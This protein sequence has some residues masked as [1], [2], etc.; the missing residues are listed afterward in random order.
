MN[1]DMLTLQSFIFIAETKSFTKA[2]N[3]IGRTQSAISQQ[4]TKLEQGLNTSLFNRDNTI[5]LTA[6][7]ELFLAYAK[8]IYA[9]YREA[10][11]K[12]K[13]PELTGRIRL[14]LPENFASLYLTEILANFSRIHP[15]ILLEI[16][17]DLTVTLFQRFKDK[18]YDLVLLKMNLPED[19]PYG[20]DM[21]SEPLKWVGHKENATLGDPIS[22][23][24]SP[25]PC[26]YRQAALS[27]L[28]QINLDWRLVFSSPSFASTV[29]AVKAGMGITVMPFTLIPPDL[30]PI[31][32]SLLPK[33]G[34]THL[35][36]VKQV[37]DNP[38][39]NTLEQ[40][41]LKKLRP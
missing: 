11:D 24:L 13:E 17:C 20:V 1:I 23:V 25:E 29:A 2:A 19:I 31:E 30:E 9:L 26:V 22:L 36:L 18:I 16:E 32:S 4:I 6:D 5:C 34:D 14:G 40:F 28:N 39:L 35:S 21:W 10:L 3:R 41:I 7:G 27:A 37:L 12:I 15:Q 8:K 33:L 38:A